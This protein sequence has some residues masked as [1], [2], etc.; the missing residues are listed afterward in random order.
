MTM[1]LSLLSSRD[2]SVPPNQYSLLPAWSPISIFGL[3]RVI[4]NEDVAAHSGQSSRYRC[5]PAEASLGREELM[6]DHAID[7]H[8][9]ED[10]EVP[11][12]FYNC[13]EL[14]GMI[15]S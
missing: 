13:A 9:R 11:I 8:F 10:A 12:G 4:Y 1:P 7:T 14:R 3:Y 6:V 2:K 15:F 5:P